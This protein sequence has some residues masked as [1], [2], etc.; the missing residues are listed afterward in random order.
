MFLFTT[1]TYEN[2][3]ESQGENG[4]RSRISSVGRMQQRE[5]AQ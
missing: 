2:V 4:A 1:S 3:R 5:F